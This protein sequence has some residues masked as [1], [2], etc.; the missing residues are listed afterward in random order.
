[1]TL[2]FSPQLGQQRRIYLIDFLYQ[3]CPV[4]PELFGRH[5][6][7]RY[8]YYDMVGVSLLAHAPGFVGI[9]DDCIINFA[10]FLKHLENFMLEGP[11]QVLAMKAW[12]TRKGA[13][14]KKAAI[15]DYSMQ[16]GVK[17]LTYSITLF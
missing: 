16:M 8:R 12:G 5:F 7:W 6:P 1:M 2:I 10:L 17:I 13:I 3:P 11:F 4:A 9:I 15:S 14:G